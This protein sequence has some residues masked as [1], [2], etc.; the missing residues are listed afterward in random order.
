M[1][2]LKYIWASI[3]GKHS[4]N[5]GNVLIEDCLAKKLN[6]PEPNLVVNIFAEKFPENLS[7]FDCIIN[8]GSTTLYP[9]WGAFE[10][11]NSMIPVIC[12]GGSIWVQD[13]Q[14]ERKRV[15]RIAKKMWKPVGCRDPFTAELLHSVSIEAK[16]IGCPTL[17]SN[18]DC[19]EADYIAFSFSRDDP[20]RQRQLLDFLTAHNRVKVMIH[21]KYERNFCL[22]SSAEV[23]N[24]PKL[25]GLV[26][27]NARCTVTGRLHGALP[28]I[29]VNKPTFFFQTKRHFDSRL[30]ILDY[31][32]LPIRKFSEISNL[33]LSRIEYDFEKTRELQEA[34]LAYTEE[35][36]EF[37]HLN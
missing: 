32:T 35:Q 28:S 21:E 17:L 20:Q 18:G 30:T 36:S 34:F 14:F 23:I 25:F 1:R 9:D 8:P 7:N 6:W 4:Q 5:F 22:N 2:N 19:A 3:G 13:D 33:D 26:Y 11:L 15:I 12:F 10:F 37:F 31:L 16:L 24:D 29:G 27:S